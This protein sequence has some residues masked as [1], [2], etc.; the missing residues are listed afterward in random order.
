MPEQIVLKVQHSGAQL[1]AGFNSYCAREDMPQRLRAVL[2]VHGKGYNLGSMF[3]WVA[4]L[5]EM[6]RYYAIP[7]SVR[8]EAVAHFCGRVEDIL[9]AAKF[10]ELHYR[11]SCKIAVPGVAVG[12]L[13]GRRMIFPFFLTYLHNGETKLCSAEQMQRIYLLLNQ[14]CSTRFPYKN[15]REFRL[16]AQM[17]HIGQPVSVIHRTGFVTSVLRISVGA[18]IFSESYSAAKGR[19]MDFLIEDEFWQIGV[20]LAKME[21]LLNALA[22]NESALEP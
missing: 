18:R 9:L 12:E 19:I 17:C 1:D 20:I 11:D 14:D 13:S 2:P 8:A 16:L 21:L 6:G 15:A 3:R 7:A 5:A 22:H 10:I 4:A